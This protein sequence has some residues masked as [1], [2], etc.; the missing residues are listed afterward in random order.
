MYNDPLKEL[1]VNTIISNVSKYSGII[2]TDVVHEIACKTIQNFQD[3]DRV[4][5]WEVNSKD[6]D[7]FGWITI[8]YLTK[9]NWSSSVTIDLKKTLRT[10]KIDKILD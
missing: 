3:L 8:S 6:F 5:E 2:T 4:T 9:S 7:K 10:H 1:I